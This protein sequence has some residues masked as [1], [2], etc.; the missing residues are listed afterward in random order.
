MHPDT[1]IGSLASAGLLLVAL[2]ALLTY[3][4]NVELDWI[5]L[6]TVGTIGLVLGIGSLIAAVV[7][8]LSSARP[9][10]EDVPTYEQRR[11]R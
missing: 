4:I 10:H 3:A 5:D 7:L 11:P 8:A 1:Q 6:A 9:D 2:G